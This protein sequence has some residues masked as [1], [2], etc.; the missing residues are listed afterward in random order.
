M[1]IKGVD[2]GFKFL[3]KVSCIIL[4]RFPDHLG[5]S[6]GT[7]DYCQENPGVNIQRKR[8]VFILIGDR[9]MIGFWL[10]ILNKT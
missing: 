4:K 7:Q 6:E 3:T 9:E 8:T 1:M 2:L 5:Y 10:Q